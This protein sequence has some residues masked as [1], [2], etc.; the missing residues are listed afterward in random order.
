[1]LNNLSNEE[2]TLINSLKLLK[3]QAGTHSPSMFTIREKLPSLEIK[4]DAC[5]LSNPYATDLFLKNFQNDLLGSDFKIRELLEFYPSQNN[6][7][8]KYLANFLKVSSDSIFIGNGAIEIIQAVIQQFCEKKIIINIPTFSS[9]YEFIKPG[10]EVVFNQ[11]KKEEDFQLNISSYIELVKKENPDTV[12]LI[13]PNNPNGAFINKNE[14]DELLSNLREVKN[15]ILDESFVHFAFDNDNLDGITFYELVE[16]YP[17]LITIKS[18]SK[19]FGIAGIRAGYSIMNPSRIKRLIGN[20]FLWNSNGLSEYFFKLYANSKFQESYE[21]VRKK[22]IKETQLFIN[23][24][25]KVNGIKCFTSKANF[26]LIELENNIKA[27]DFAFGLL[28]KEGIYVRTCSDKIGL[29]NSEYIRLASRSKQENELIIKA[30]QSI[31]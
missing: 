9:Y 7:I 31:F 2:L 10:V 29:Q 11:L 24:I 27:D 23:A 5:F 21:I 20:G 22:Y 14:I 1:M 26:V 18:M 25:S 3:E 6:V 30:I 15:I 4:I 16:K 19:D 28:V 8:A 13:N 17:N 12:V